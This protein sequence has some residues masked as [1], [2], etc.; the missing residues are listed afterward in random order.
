MDARADRPGGASGRACRGEPDLTGPAP[1]L[2]VMEGG[3]AAAPV[4]QAPADA[5][6][7]ARVRLASAHAARLGVP[8]VAADLREAMAATGPAPEA[9]AAGLRAAGLVVR[10]EAVPASAP[11]RWP[12]L[13]PALAEMTGGRLVLVLAQEAGTLVLLE[14]DAPDGRAEVP[15]TE[16]APHFTGRV[17]RADAPAAAQDLPEKARHWFW[18]EFAALRRHVAEVAVGSLVANLLA[19]AVALFALQVYDRVIPH[20]SEATLWVL[21]AGAA[22]ALLMEAMLKIARAQLMDGAGRQIEV[23]VQR[24]LMD[25]LLG[26]KAQLA[27]RS[28]ASLFSAMREFGSVREFFTATTIG[29]LADI[30][31][32]FVF[33]ALVAS[34]AGNVVWV[35]VLGGILMVVPGFLMQRRMIR[36]T[37]QMQS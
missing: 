18:G 37:Q 2:S 35:L 13:W 14:A 23:R 16:F 7:E 3:A 5:R 25:R 1:A 10:I 28:P 9:L 6:L 15:L 31:F 34:I 33:L 30:P 11:D 19:V 17:V 4:S 26:M 21:A 22:M 20:Q 29:T 36:L 24:L 12:D 32:I 27:G 8:V